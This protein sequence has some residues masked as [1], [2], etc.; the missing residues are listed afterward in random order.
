MKKIIVLFGIIFLIFV[1]IVFFQLN[2]KTI[3]NLSRNSPS[4]K[5]SINSATFKVE[6]AKTQKEQEIGLSGRTSL[7]DTQGMLFLYDKPTY[8]NFWMRGMKFPLDMIFIVDNKVVH[9]YENLTP[10]AKDDDN[11]PQWGSDVMADKV[12]EINAGLSRKN[13]IK[14]GDTVTIELK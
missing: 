10:A 5:I 3:N 9:V 11:P 2:V 12:L 4:S 13:D 6:L 1:V 7:P 8:N 14:T